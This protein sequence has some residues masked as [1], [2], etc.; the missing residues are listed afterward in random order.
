[1][2]GTLCRDPDATATK[3]AFGKAWRWLVTSKSSN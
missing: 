3:D 1:M 2:L